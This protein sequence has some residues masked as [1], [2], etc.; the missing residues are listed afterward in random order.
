MGDAEGSLAQAV[1]TGLVC[2]VQKLR[3]EHGFAWS[4]ETLRGWMV[5][6]GLWQVWQSRVVWLAVLFVAQF[7]RDPPRV[8]HHVQRL[9]LHL[10][11][12]PRPHPLPV[13]L[14]HT[15][16]DPLFRRVPLVG[17]VAVVNLLQPPERVLERLLHRLLRSAEGHRVGTVMQPER[18]TDRGRSRE[19]DEGGR[20]HGESGG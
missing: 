19:A 9:A 10:D 2:A 7:F 5:Q 4:V 14:P 18:V 16:V 20:C 3:R 15:Q 17:P 1:S 11:G 8:V 13:D 12:V 6:A